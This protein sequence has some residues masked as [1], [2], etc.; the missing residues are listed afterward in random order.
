MLSAAE[1][2]CPENCN[3]HGSNFAEQAI[4]IGIP[5]E[6][7]FAHA[8]LFHHL[9]DQRKHILNEFWHSVN[10]N[11]NLDRVVPSLCHWLL[12]DKEL[13]VIQYVK[14]NNIVEVLIEVAELCRLNCSEEAN[15]MELRIRLRALRTSNFRNLPDSQGIGLAGDICLFN[16]SPWI[17]TP[18]LNTWAGYTQGLSSK[19][20]TSTESRYAAAWM[21]LLALIAD[22][23]T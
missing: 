16:T 7:C 19:L 3:L 11:A 22:S 20:Q 17:M 21:K 10:V 18:T 9:P 1:Q 15:W 14:K 12:T 8:T 23:S 5:V 6:L 13:G 2:G 4:K